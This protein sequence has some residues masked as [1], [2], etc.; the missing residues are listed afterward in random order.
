MIW[1]LRASTSMR[2]IK[3]ELVVEILGVM[4]NYTIRGVS[5]VFNAWMG[6]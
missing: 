4:M 5:E 1:H 2:P 3:R 6:V